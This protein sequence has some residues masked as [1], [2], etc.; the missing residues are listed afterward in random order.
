MKK[1]LLYL[2]IFLLLLCSCGILN[3]D[4]E[5][6]LDVSFSV[7][8]NSI[9][10]YRLFKNS[11]SYEYDVEW[12]ARSL[13]L[14]AKKGNESH[15][16]SFLNITWALVDSLNPSEISSFDVKIDGHD[17]SY[18]EMHMD[19]ELYYVYA[20]N[21]YS[22]EFGYYLN[23][24]IDLKAT[25]AQG[26]IDWSFEINASG[27]S[28]DQNGLYR[29]G[30]KGMTKDIIVAKDAS[31][32]TVKASI[33]VCG[34][35][36]IIADLKVNKAG[37]LVFD[38]SN[39]WLLHSRKLYKLDKNSGIIESETINLEIPEVYIVDITFDGTNFW[40]LEFYRSDSVNLYKMNTSG[41]L[42]KKF[43]ISNINNGPMTE[44]YFNGGLSWDGSNLWTTFQGKSYA[45][46]K[47]NTNGDILDYH[48]YIPSPHFDVNSW[49]WQYY[50]GI[51]TMTWDGNRLCGIG[52]NGRLGC[53]Q[54][55]QENE[56]FHFAGQG[57]EWDGEC[58][59]ISMGTVTKVSVMIIKPK[60]FN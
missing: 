49:N 21:D 29:A 10:I 31:N 52:E 25:G 42:I 9:T 53:F 38:Q 1:N 32:H 27:G 40:L 60:S 5:D 47:I 6:Q 7:D 8:G 24:K 51:E 11:S 50:I 20:Q 12:G 26:K 37:P 54:N 46:F 22:E 39:M 13:E 58:F 44:P 55:G 17:F 23:D 48:K 3:P 30:Q 43:D 56:Y 15:H 16:L 19:G 34:A 59:W 57:I 18:A 2:S 33:F 41:R 28:I 4:N 35:F 36:D 14:T 45:F